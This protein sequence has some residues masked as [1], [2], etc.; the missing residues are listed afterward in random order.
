[1]LH[2]TQNGQVLATIPEGGWAD[3]PNGD[4]VSPAVAGWTNGEFSL[5]PVPQTP[6]P[7]PQE[8]L[9][10]ERASM[11][12]SFAQLLIGL[13]SEGWITAT[14]GRAWRDRTALP[15][16]VTAL[17]A[18]LPDAQQFAAETRAMAPSVVERNDPLVVMLGATQGK[19][20]DEL[21]AF[22]RNYATV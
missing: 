6:D 20:P 9:E 10:A 4:R 19:A 12:L 13:V 16:P 5:V 11:S 3:L 7:T 17:I 2:L 21:D 14:E 1:M 18:T 15:A 22:F 8:L